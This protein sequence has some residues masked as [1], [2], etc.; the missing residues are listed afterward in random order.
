MYT[1]ACGFVA[2]TPLGFHCHLAAASLDSATIHRPCSAPAGA[3][4]SPLP[5]RPA[6]NGKRGRDA[7]AAVAGGAGG[8]AL[9]MAPMPFALP[10]W[11]ALLDAPPRAPSMDGRAPESPYPPAAKRTVTPRRA[12]RGNAGP[13][14]AAAAAAAEDLLHIGR[15]WGKGDDALPT[16]RSSSSS[17][18]GGAI[19]RAAHAALSR[20][21]TPSAAATAARGAPAGGG[22]QPRTRRRSGDSVASSVSSYVMAASASMPGLPASWDPFAPPERRR[23]G[24]RGGWE[25]W[26]QISGGVGGGGGGCRGDAEACPWEP[27]NRSNPAS[28]VTTAAAAANGRVRANR[29]RRNEPEAAAMAASS[30]FSVPL[31]RPPG[32]GGNTSAASPAAHSTAAG[33]SGGVY[34]SASIGSA[35]GGSGSWLLGAVGQAAGAVLSAA[36][37]AAAAAALAL[38]MPPATD[39]EGSSSLEPARHRHQQQQHH[40]QQQQQQPP[41][42]PPPEARRA[43]SNWAAAPVPAAVPA[44]RAWQGP[45]PERALSWGSSVEDDSSELLLSSDS[46][47]G[48][49]LA[50]NGKAEAAATPSSRVLVPFNGGLAASVTAPPARRRNGN[51]VRWA[52]GSVSEEGALVPMPL[53]PPGALVLPPPAAR[54][55]EVRA[56][57]L[58]CDPGASARALAAGLYL[59]LLVGCLPRGLAYLQLTSLL[60][61]AGLCFL[62]YNLAKRPLL[63]GYAWVVGADP[64]HAARRLARAEAAAGGAAAVAAAAAAAAAVSWAFG[65]AALAARALRGRSFTATAWTVAGLWALLLLSELRLVPQLLLAMGAYCGLFAV[66][67]LYCRFRDAM[68]GLVYEAVHFAALVVAGC[69]R[70][71]LAGAAALGVGAWHFLDGA[72]APLV[73]RASGGAAA[74]GG[75]LVWRTAAA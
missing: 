25:H 32:V 13:A 47:E 30:C 16:P 53:A 17:G 51:A 6:S 27:V 14:A 62:A 5:V 15:G 43:L 60:P 3:A 36:T 66:P 7:G 26:D 20:P 37:S 2:A 50:I 73:V 8:T 10:A 67:W 74:A 59:I 24:G 49:G 72:G 21:V 19:H 31:M 65:G 58:W 29:P 69:D 11:A 22:R 48:G 68:D 12:R 9:V 75:V 34:G 18:G 33:W 4:P 61:A 35:V 56:L 52:G 38:V 23:R 46:E 1:C 45:A 64:E 70:A 55:A 44:A 54:R 63:R 57:L 71:T 41:P 39:S 28:S 40:Q 42:P